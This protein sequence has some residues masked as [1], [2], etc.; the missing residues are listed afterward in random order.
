MTP[1]AE[2]VLWTA[3]LAT[4]VGA[5]LGVLVMTS[6]PAAATTTPPAP[7]KIPQ[8]ATWTPVALMPNL[9]DPSLKSYQLGPGI[10]RLSLDSQANVQQGSPEYT[11]LLNFMQ[12]IPAQQENKLVTYD[13]TNTPA[14]WPASDRAKPGRIRSEFVIPQ[15][16]TTSAIIPQAYN[17]LVWTKSA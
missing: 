13:D 12:S 4:L 3:G 7:P 11:A 8:G 17:D 2:R 9:F 16:A 10:Y 1:N 5:S 14:D 6:K 15:G